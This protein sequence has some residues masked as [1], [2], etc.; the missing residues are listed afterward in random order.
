MKDDGEEG[1]KDNWLGEARREE[2][3][4]KARDIYRKHGTR[5]IM[6]YQ[7]D[8]EDCQPLGMFLD[9]DIYLCERQPRSIMVITD[10]RKNKKDLNFTSESRAIK[11]GFLMAQAAGIK[12]E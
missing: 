11:I 12:K 9:Y 10:E 5:A 8:C 1:E 6:R 4:L 3:A 7:H 2:G